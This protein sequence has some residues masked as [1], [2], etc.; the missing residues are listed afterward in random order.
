MSKSA[1]YMKKFGLMVDLY[2]GSTLFTNTKDRSEFIL[3]FTQ[4]VLDKYISD[5]I[6]C[7]LQVIR[8]LARNKASLRSWTPEM[9]NSELRRNDRF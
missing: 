3:Y 2:M 4:Q 1:E 9:T 8:D 5:V 7:T 6:D